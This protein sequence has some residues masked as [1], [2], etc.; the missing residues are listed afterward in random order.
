MKT[1][2]QELNEQLAEF[3]SA[4]EKGGLPGALCH[5]NA[6]TS[7]RYTAIYRLDGQMM[8]NI[9]IYDRQSEST[10]N[11]SEMPLG[12][13]FCR[14]VMADNGFSTANSA[15]D[16]RPQGH[17]YRGILNA[18][19]GLPLSRKPGTIY[20]TFCHF[21]FEPMQIADSEIPLIEAAASV[22][23]DHLEQEDSDT[24]PVH[25]QAERLLPA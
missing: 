14:F 9:H 10:A 8:R 20:G 1:A 4:V 24:G 12:D 22:L 7:Y 16:D 2:P 5:R 18:Y 17:S 23:M 19:V 25:I 6:R 3:R 21:D 11:L 13:S 15:T